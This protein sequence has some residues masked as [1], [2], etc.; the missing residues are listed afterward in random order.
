MDT[1]DLANLLRFAVDPQKQTE[2]GNLILTLLEV[3]QIMGEARLDFNPENSEDARRIKRPARNVTGEEV[4]W[5]DLGQGSYWVTYRERVE[6]PVG[7][8]LFLQ[9]HVRLLRNGIWHPTTLIR[10]WDRDMDGMMLTVSS[11]GIR[12]SEKAPVSLGTIIQPD[13]DQS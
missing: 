6:I 2:G 5:W 10:D 13:R 11:R 1:E 7:C 4:G 9:P 12:I 8:A 3:Q